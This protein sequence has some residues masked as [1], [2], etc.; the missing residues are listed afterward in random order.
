MGCSPTGAVT[1]FISSSLQLMLV[2]ALL[3]YDVGGLAKG[4]L[5]VYNT[6]SYVSQ[7]FGSKHLHGSMLSIYINM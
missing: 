2:P 6:A 7:L 3:E 1:A 4:A 5:F